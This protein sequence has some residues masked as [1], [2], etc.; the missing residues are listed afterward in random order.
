[1]NPARDS[2]QLV[3]ILDRQFGYA[4]KLEG[5]D[6]LRRLRQVLD[7]ITAEP[8]FAGLLDDMRNDW[9]RRNSELM[10]ADAQVRLRLLALWEEFGGAIRSV[11]GGSQDEALFA[12]GT[13]DSYPRRLVVARQIG[14]TSIDLIRDAS[15]E[16]LVEILRHWRKW[17]TDRFSRDEGT[18]FADAPRFDDE[19]DAIDDQRFFVDGEVADALLRG[20][21]AFSR[22]RGNVEAINPIPPESAE[23]LVRLR[24]QTA[25]SFARALAAVD[26]DIRVSAGEEND[27]DITHFEVARDM[28]ILHEDLRLRVGLE[29]TRIGLVRRFA[30]RCEAF[31]GDRLR[32]ACDADRGNAE[33]ILTLELARYLFDAGV[34]VYIDATI[35]GLRPDLFN[36]AQRRVFYVEAKQYAG[37]NP[38][39]QIRRAYHQVWSTWGRLRNMFSTQD[40]SEAFLVVFRRAG[41][42]VE[43][44]PVIRDQGLRLHTVLVDLSEQAGSRERSPP[45]AITADELRPATPAES[46]SEES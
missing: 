18:D 29:R 10:E 7:L 19:L 25:R 6:R 13:F 17:C 11:L 33:R 15:T 27:V 35:S 5:L 3:D 43:L 9:Q 26:A 16:R 31:E 34:P 14:A 38:R 2:D 44:P 21:P 40:T 12:L 8:A 42:Y 46:E 39:H 28:Q 20:W 45:I 24:H 32:T 1:M 37:D 23:L 36:A 30:A 4:S 41:P 22:L